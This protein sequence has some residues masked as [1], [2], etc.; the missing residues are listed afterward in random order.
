MAFS[1]LSCAL[2][3]VLLLSDFL[4]Y[5][6]RIF[7]V[8]IF[9]SSLTIFFRSLSLRCS[10][11]CVVD[12]WRN[13]EE[14]HCHTEKNVTVSELFLQRTDQVCKSTNRLLLSTGTSDRPE[15]IIKFWSEY[16][17]CFFHSSEK[18]F[19]SRICSMIY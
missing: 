17:I 6:S 9:L 11:Q 5:F 18:R 4:P 1:S 7:L 16:W 15:K 10:V 13:T 8:A 12:W 3:S 14:M 2:V 19:H